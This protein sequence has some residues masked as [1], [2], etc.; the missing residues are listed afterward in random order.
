MVFQNGFNVIWFSFIQHRLYDSFDLTLNW[1][2][3]NGSKIKLTNNWFKSLQICQQYFRIWSSV[4]IRINWKVF[5]FVHSLVLKFPYSIGLEKKCVVK[6]FKLELN[7]ITWNFFHINFKI[8][9]KTMW[10]RSAIYITNLKS[11][12]LTWIVYSQETSHLNDYYRF[13]ALHWC[14]KLRPLNISI[15]S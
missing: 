15:Q 2:W 12:H 8:L 3:L 4:I 10:L 14:E 1:K 5:T 13:V 11:D 7:L 9:F 6:E